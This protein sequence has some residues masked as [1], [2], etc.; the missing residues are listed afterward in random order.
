MTNLVYL[1][2][3]HGGH[4]TGA[5]GCNFYEKERALTLT[6]LVEKELVGQ[7][8][9]VKLTRSTDVFV[10]LKERANKANKDNAALFVSF[11]LNAGG[12][13]GYETFTHTS[14]STGSVKLQNHLHDEAMKVLKPLGFKDRGKKNA[15]LSV[16]RNTKM[17]AVLT[18]N[19]FIDS[20]ADMAHIGK[21]TL[22]EQLATAYAKAIMLNLGLTY[23][24]ICQPDDKTSQ[25]KSNSSLTYVQIGAFSDKT[26]AKEL[27]EK[28]KKAGFNVTLK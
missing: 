21:D 25:D 8:V 19:G 6:K 17:P 23:K 15:N 11:H 2:A 27:A 5:I 14:R 10:E 7:G 12:G 26:N 3:G 28:A 24:V 18:E 1:D 4:D 9:P 20:V 22:L 16:T 13:E